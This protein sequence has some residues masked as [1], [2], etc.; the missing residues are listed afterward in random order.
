[1][2]LRVEIEKNGI[3]I[4]A[5]Y[6]SGSTA[7][8]ARFEY[9]DEYISEGNKPISI[10]LPTDERKFS[11]TQTQIYF[12]GLLPEGFTRGEV[13]RSI[14]V[15]A[16]DYIGILSAL[17]KECLGAIKVTATDDP[18]YEEPTYERLELARVK[19]LA[20]EGASA[21]AELVTKS[22]LSLTGAS[23]K[24]GLYYDADNET[25]YLPKGSAPSTHI[26]K[27]SH[28]RLSGIVVNEQLALKTAEKLGIDIPRSFIFSTGGNSD[29]DVLLATERY[30]RLF[31]K[32]SRQISGMQAPLRLHQEDFAQAMGIN[33]FRKYE[34]EGEEYLKDM[35]TLLRKQ[36]S[37][38]IEDQLK[39]WDI[40]VFNYLIGN[41]DGHIKNFSLLYDKDMNSVRLAPA[42]DLVCTTIYESTSRNMAFNIGGETLIDNIDRECFKRA[43]VDAGISERAALGR[44][45]MMSERFTD[46]LNESAEELADIGYRYAISIKD[47]IM[48]RY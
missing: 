17:G 31:S 18:A 34:R 35:F 8:D 9:S 21:T 48:R 16:N 10:S 20:A 1:M 13:A 46:A 7:A 24:T 40:I 23:G 41:T 6:I 19:A 28:V 36:S 14:H 37:N 2:K 27:Q 43:S 30:D 47:S 15:D 5:G 45:D 39:L 33:S 29:A 44:F 32:E 25:W 3:M 38:P 42:Y 11:P 12:E 4:T 22:H 26:V